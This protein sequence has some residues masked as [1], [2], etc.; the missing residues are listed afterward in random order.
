F[1]EVFTEPSLLPSPTRPSLNRPDSEYY[2]NTTGSPTQSIF[3]IND[4]PVSA[5]ISSSEA[6]ILRKVDS[7]INEKFWFLEQTLKQHFEQPTARTNT[8]QSFNNTHQRIK[9]TMPSPV[10]LNSNNAAYFQPSQQVQEVYSETT[11]HADI[12]SLNHT[13]Q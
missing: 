9:L 6:E 5:D 7:R 2:F 4:T 3:R 10:V 12:E 13:S 11:G 8:P 1:N